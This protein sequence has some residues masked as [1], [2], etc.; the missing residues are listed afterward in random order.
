[1]MVRVSRSAG[2]VEAV[3]GNGT[4]VARYPATTGSKYDPLPLGEWKINGV[5]RNPTYNYNPDLFWDAEASEKKVK[6]AAGPNSPV[7]AVW[8]DLS[9]RT[10][11][12]MGRLCLR[13]SAR[14]ARTAASV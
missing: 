6:L 11:A 8:I 9:S 14:P 13:P 5:A 7:G 2:A 10:T 12:S 1:M 4:V 3:D